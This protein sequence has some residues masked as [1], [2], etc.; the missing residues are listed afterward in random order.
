[1]VPDLLIGSLRSLLSACL[2][3][4][5][6]GRSFFLRRLPRENFSMN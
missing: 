1:M 5:R 4:A 2:R 3:A 6:P